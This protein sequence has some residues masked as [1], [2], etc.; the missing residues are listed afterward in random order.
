M[1]TSIDNYANQDVLRDKKS[2]FSPKNS[3]KSV[4][5]IMVGHRKIVTEV[6]SDLFNSKG[7]L[8]C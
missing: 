2:F 6:I 3:V 8:V 7:I 5:R 4:V 1:Y